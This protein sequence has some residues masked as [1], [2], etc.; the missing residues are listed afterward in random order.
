MT[1]KQRLIVFV[2]LET[3]N[4]SL[5]KIVLLAKAESDI[6]CFFHPMDKNLFRS[7]QLAGEL[8]YCSGVVDFFFEKIYEILIFFKAV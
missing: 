5:K 8:I 7:I 6:S 3:N 4:K 2:Y 1:I